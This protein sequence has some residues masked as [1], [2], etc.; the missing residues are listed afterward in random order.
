VWPI[1]V[2]EVLPDPVSPEVEWVEIYNDSSVSATLVNWRIRDCTD[3]NSTLF[4]ATI[5]EFSYYKI[6]NSKSYFNNTSDDCVRLFDPESNLIDEQPLKPVPAHQSYSRQSD[7]SWCLTDPSP[8]IKNNSCLSFITPVPTPSLSPT[9]SP[10]IFLDLIDVLPNPDDA[11]EWVKIKN[12]NSF[13]VSLDGWKIKNQSGYTRNLPEINIDPNSEY[14]AYFTSGFLRNSGGSATLLDF[15][16]REIDQISWSQTSSPTSTKKPTGTKKPTSTKKPA[17][18]L[19][20]KTEVCQVASCSSSIS[21]FEYSKDNSFSRYISVIFMFIGS[22][23]I[24][25]PWLSFKKK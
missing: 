22:L 21:N 19:G 18:V 15:N 6:E 24:L 12:P 3:T 17:Q 8:Q 20:V 2:T 4:S 10:Q 16:K 11:D 23:L 7:N 1:I 25:L 9:L 14:I 5:S 13:S